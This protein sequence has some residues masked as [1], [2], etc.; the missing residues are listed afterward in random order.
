MG[1]LSLLHYTRIAK[2]KSSRK[3]VLRIHR[4][5]TYTVGGGG[6]GGGGSLLA[7]K[8]EGTCKHYI[9][10]QTPSGYNSYPAGKGGEYIGG[11]KEKEGL[12]VLT[13]CCKFRRCAAN[14][15][16]ALLPWR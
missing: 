7:A 13:F 9:I 1:S 2:D 16:S 5:P 6:G 3:T 12:L 10:F 15:R 14:I 8:D 11:T 4:T